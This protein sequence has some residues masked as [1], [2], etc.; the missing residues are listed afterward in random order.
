LRAGL[1]YARKQ[2]FDVVQIFDT[3]YGTISVLLHFFKNN[4]PPIA[5][6]VNAPNFAYS[7]YSGPLLIKLYKTLQKKLLGSLLGTRIR[8][9][10]MLGEFHREEFRRQ[11]DLPESFPIAVIYDGADTPDTILSNEEAR[12]KLVIPFDGTLFLFFGML[13][14]DKGI[15]SFFEAISLVQEK[16][17]KVLMAGSLFDYTEVELKDLIK[18][19]GIEDKIILRTGYIDDKD[20]NDYFFASD[21]LVLPYG[22]LYRGGSGP[23]LK[24][25]AVCKVPAI[26][27][28]IA[29]MGRLVR[30]HDMGLIAEA[31][32]PSSLSL[33]ME[34][35]LKTPPERR[36]EMGEHAFLA[37]N[38]W[39]T[40]AQGYESFYNKII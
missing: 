17:F 37:A 23:L 39:K 16:N 11:F 14:R 29:E 22:K 25:G 2:G 20:V 3:E 27:S 1:I 15:E 9:V 33:A 13:R 6:M 34:E 30:Q 31:E 26:V 5:L 18:H 38:T 32:N 36:R 12:A 10:N 19:F 7:E 35:F 8:G 4:L 24:Q 21:V 40:M 28:D